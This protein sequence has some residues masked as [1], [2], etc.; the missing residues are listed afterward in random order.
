MPESTRSEASPGLCATCRHAQRVE[1]PRAVYW[2]CRLSFTDPRFDKYPRLPVR[3][4][5]GYE[6][7]EPEEPKPLPES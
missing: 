1:T 7:S 3:A 5:D 2:L 4:C 6:R